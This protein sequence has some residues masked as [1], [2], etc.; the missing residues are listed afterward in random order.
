S[1]HSGCY[2]PAADRY[3]KSFAGH[4]QG[5]FPQLPGV[6]FFGVFV[7]VF[8]GCRGWWFF[9]FVCVWWFV[10]W[11]LGVGFVGGFVWGLFFCGVFVGGGWVGC[12]CVC[13]GL[14]VDVCVV[15]GELG[16]MW[17]EVVGV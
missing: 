2:G 6:V 7:C 8:W 15:W 4:S 13:C 17:V 3:L 14:V 16:G 5:I 10:V 9:G 11:W 1:T 12:G